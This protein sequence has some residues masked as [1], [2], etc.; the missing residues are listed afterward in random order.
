M[1]GFP[2]YDKKTLILINLILF[3]V[4]LVLV[5]NVW[6][7]IGLEQLWG[8]SL[9]S[10]SRV[11]IVIS[12][13]V[14]VSSLF[15][16]REINRLAETEQ[17]AKTN[18]ILL[19]ESKETITLLRT[20]RHDFMNHLQVIIGLL[21]LN[22][23]DDSFEYV[24]Q[25]I[26]DMKTV[27]RESAIENPIMAA[28]FMKKSSLAEQRDVNLITTISSQLYGIPISF[29]DLSRIVGNLID[30]AIYAAA[31]DISGN[32]VVEVTF[33]ESFDAYLISVQNTG[34]LIPEELSKKIFE[35]GFTTKGSDGSGLG[36]YIVRSLVEKNGGQIE[37]N[38]KDGTTVFNLMF[39]KGN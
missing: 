24:N 35:K 2:E 13:I 12:V 32:K 26:G 18:Q 11:T 28:L 34:A 8:V 1:N 10:L 19:D 16:L 3:E 33:S 39:P 21:Q 6:V 22:K 5:T 36:L 15:L 14:G 4:L 27:F 25:I 23:V 9:N 29:I 31:K 17:E 38:N 7:S 37:L 20:H 30:N